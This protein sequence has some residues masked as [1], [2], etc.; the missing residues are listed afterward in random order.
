ML[1]LTGISMNTRN[2]SR[3]ALAKIDTAIDSVSR[4]RGAVGA[5]M[6]RLEYTLN[7]TESAIESVTALESTLRDADYAL[8]ATGL[9]RTQILGQMSQMAMINSR[10][11][12]QTV[13]S[14]LAA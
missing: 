4:E 13:M 2:G 3:E 8:E 14:L 11:P 1:N 10:V 6:N 5:I 7:F 9:A 12:V